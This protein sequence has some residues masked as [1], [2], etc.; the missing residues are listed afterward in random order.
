MFFKTFFTS[1]IWITLAPKVGYMAVG[2][3]LTL[4]VL[5]AIALAT[6]PGPVGAGP[7]SPAS[8]PA[9]TETPQPTLTPRP[10]TPT[11]DP[12]KEMEKSEEAA[13]YILK[14]EYKT[15]FDYLCDG[16]D[17]QKRIWDWEKDLTRFEIRVADGGYAGS[18]RWHQEIRELA[19]ELQALVVLIDR[20][21][22]E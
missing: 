17:T 3:V 8:T 12:T 21:C 4:V 11:P 10:P 2:A 20:Q 22:L 14:W 18:D 16:Y 19:D 13:R 5:G 15:Q 6:D 9:V 1:T 7:A